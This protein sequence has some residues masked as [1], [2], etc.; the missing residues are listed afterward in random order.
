MSEVKRFEKIVEVDGK[1]YKFSGWYK[2]E[3]CSWEEVERE[4]EKTIEDLRRL[5]S[6]IIPFGHCDGVG[7]F[8]Y[9][10]KLI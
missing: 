1:R 10:F 2:P 3:R 4:I 8:F 6:F 5:K 7:R 9:G